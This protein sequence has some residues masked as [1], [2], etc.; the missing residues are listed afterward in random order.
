MSAIAALG[1]AA[2]GGVTLASTGLKVAQQG[3]KL[4]ID[5]LQ[6]D[7]GGLVAKLAIV[8]GFAWVFGQIIQVSNGLNVWLSGILKFLGFNV[9]QLPK[10]VIDFYNTGF[11]GVQY[12]D[13]VKVGLILI[14]GMEFY[15]YKKSCDNVGQSLNPATVAVFLIILTGIMALTLPGLWSRITFAQAVAK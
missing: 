14:V 6:Y 8:Y 12:W 13:L 2:T 5:L 15:R 10:W 11:N 7:F 1:A 3:R 9:P 4:G